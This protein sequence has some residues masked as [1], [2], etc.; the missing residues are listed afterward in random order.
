MAELCVAMYWAVQP[1]Y[2]LV[3]TRLCDLW[4]VLFF[5]KMDGLCRVLFK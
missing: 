1:W 5:T 4:H 2:V 3:F